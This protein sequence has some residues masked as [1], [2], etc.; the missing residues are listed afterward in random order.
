MRAIGPTPRPRTATP[1]LTNGPSRHNLQHHR[2][3]RRR[4]Q[5]FNPAATKPRDPRPR[6]NPAPPRPG[7]AKGCSGGWSESAP[8]SREPAVRSK[9]NPAPEGAA[10][11]S[12]QLRCGAPHPALLCPPTLLTNSITSI[13]SIG[14][15]PAACQSSPSLRRPI[16][17]TDFARKL[18]NA[19]DW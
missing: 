3:S 19:S 6:I 13:S 18:N 16:M 10:E 11:A 4:A 1:A 17:P 15:I 14:S 12:V 7:G 8:G 9:T 5:P 2:P